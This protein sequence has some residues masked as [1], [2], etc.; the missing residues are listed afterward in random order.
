MKL[1]VFSDSH[2]NVANMEDAVR[3]E[4]PDQVLHLGDV[5]R[6]A[7]ALRRR[8]PDLPMTRVRGNCDARSDVPEECLLERAGRRLLLMHGH[9]RFVKS[10]PGAA[11]AA[12]REARA[13]VLL[14][15]HTHDALC[16]L[17]GNL[18]ILNPGAAGGLLF[19]S[20][21]VVLLEADG[22]YCYT[23]PI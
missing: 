11:V 17:Q 6:D 3:R 15:G 7:D 19:R 14:C 10:G 5:V 21:G 16:D 8:F 4:E 9:T 1:L 23:Q 20:Y 2:G 12:A 13:D 18:W 22:V